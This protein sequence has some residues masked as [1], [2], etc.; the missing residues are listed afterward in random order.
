MLLFFDLPKKI[1][2]NTY[3][4]ARRKVEGKEKRFMGQ[5]LYR[6]YRSKSLDEIVGQKHVTEVLSAAVSSGR[7]NHAYLLTGPRGVG[8]TSIA[9]ILAH[10]INKLEYSDETTHLD[11]IEIDAA[12]NRRIDDIR[13]LREKVHITPTSA[14]YKVYIID[15]VHMLTGE[16]FNA[17]LKTL[18]EP[19]EHVIF[20]LATT[21]PHKLPAT[22]IS[23]TQRFHFKPIT[24]SHMIEHLADIAKKEK[25][26][27]DS[28][29]LQLIA[30][31][32]DGSFRDGISLL[33][34][35]ASLVGKKKITTKLI[36]DT[37]GLAPQTSV[38][39]LLET[40]DSH[41]IEKVV[42]LLNQ[43]ED[44][45]VSPAVLTNQLLLLLRKKITSRPQYIQLINE[46][47]E[48]PRGYHPRLKLL[49]ILALA[50]TP[51]KSIALST[52]ATASIMIDAP[53]QLKSS[54]RIIHKED[55][56]Q[57]KKEG[58][59]SLKQK[60]TAIDDSPKNIDWSA[61]LE[62]TRKHYLPLHSVL[63][64]ADVK[65]EGGELSL[66][67][68]YGL[69]KKKLEDTKYR[70]MLS[71]SIEAVCGSCPAIQMTSG[72]RPPKNKLA[73]EVAAIMGGG[74]EI[75]VSKK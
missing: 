45:G 61:V 28:N 36:E 13:D 64:R 55:I 7:I 38:E 42:A 2:L 48:V 8:K 56:K 72:L 9:R 47:L 63:S 46:L 52:S 57:P 24:D 15:E 37:L 1:D 21:E 43:L 59:S 14:H 20:I 23:R 71:S 53:T 3:N 33:D 35:L 31:Y 40:V 60:A 68:T 5:A 50:A 30:T 4:K 58:Q 11:I 22:I 54:K 70:T 65:Y 39:T 10:D 41:D 49:T 27:V 6:K 16:S 25:I 17:L 26:A 51:S 29:A 66:H 73:N 44:S 67:F 19:P 18:E 75:D 69:H 12:S 32:S 62:Y 34:Q 74:E